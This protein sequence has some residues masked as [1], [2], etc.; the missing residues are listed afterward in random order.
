MIVSFMVSHQASGGC[1]TAG[2]CCAP[3]LYDIVQINGYDTYTLPHYFVPKV[4]KLCY[5]R[6]VPTVAEPCPW[7][8]ETSSHPQCHVKLV[9]KQAACYEW[10][11]AIKDMTELA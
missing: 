3:S 1:K 2:L 11:D 9:S 7:I 8:T 4:S 6:S 10:G 5:L